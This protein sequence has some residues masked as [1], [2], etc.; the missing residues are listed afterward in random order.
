MTNKILFPEPSTAIIHSEKHI[1]QIWL[2]KINEKGK[3]IYLR[4]LYSWILPTAVT[5]EGWFAEETD[6]IN[7]QNNSGK[8]IKFEL[9]KGEFV[10]NGIVICQYLAGLL[11]GKNLSE[12][13][14]D[15]HIIPNSLINLS[16]GENESAIA[17]KF[18]VR[19]EVLLPIDHLLIPWTHKA[20]PSPADFSVFV[21]QLFFLPKVNLLEFKEYDI[22]GVKTKDLIIQLSN[23]I[24]NATGFNITKESAPR[25]GNLEWF[26]LPASDLN[27]DPLISFGVNKTDELTT[28]SV[29][30]YFKPLTSK[31][32]DIVLRCRIINSEEVALDE[33]RETR[34]TEETIEFEFVCSQ[35]ASE[36]QVTVWEYNQ[37]KSSAFIIFEQSHHCI[38]T[39]STTT[40]MIGSQINSGQISLLDK[41]NRKEETIKRA[42]LAKFSRSTSAGTTEIG[43]YEKDPWVNSSRNIIGF[44]KHLFPEKSE[45]KFFVNGWDEQQGES[46]Q[47]LFVEWILKI[48]SGETESSLILLDPFLD[49]DGIEI[50]AHAR[51]TNTQY[52]IV[53]CTQHRERVDQTTET[54]ATTI[55]DLTAQIPKEDTVTKAGITIQN[56]CKVILPLL[57]SLNLTI[58]DLR[59]EDKGK[60]QL[61]HD[62]YLLLL[63]KDGDLLKGFH[64]SNSLQGATRKAPLLVT[65]IP[66]DILGEVYK[67][68]DNLINPVESS[69]GSKKVELVKLYPFV[70]EARQINKVLVGTTHL[71]VGKL[72]EIPDQ[73]LFFSLLLNKKEIINADLNSLYIQLKEREIL[74]DDSESFLIFNVTPDDLAIF[75]QGL[76]TQNECDFSK[77][78]TALGECLARS[79]TYIHVSD[80]D[81]KAVYDAFQELA[82]QVKKYPGLADKLVT[83]INTYKDGAS[84]RD[85]DRIFQ[86]FNV[87]SFEDGVESAQ[88]HLSSTSGDFLGI[89]YSYYYASKLLIKCFPH[90]AVKL[91]EALIAKAVALGWNEAREEVRSVLTLISTLGQQFLRYFTYSDEVTQS[92]WLRSKDYRIR[93]ASVGALIHGVLYDHDW[94]GSYTNFEHLLLDCLVDEEYRL[95]I[96]AFNS[97][98]HIRKNLPNAKALLE[99]SYKTISNDWAGDEQLITHVIKVLGGRLEHNYSY[100][101]SLNF[102]DAIIEDNKLSV[103]WCLNFWNTVFNRKIQF[104]Q[105]YIN[106]GSD[107]LPNHFSSNTDVELTKTII[108]YFRKLSTEEQESVA[109]NWFNGIAP[110]WAVI[111]QPFAYHSNFNSFDG[112]CERILWVKIL[113]DKLTSGGLTAK[114]QKQVDTFLALHGREILVAEKHANTRRLAPILDLTKI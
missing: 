69:L 114:I 5:K 18:T 37:E 101:I 13:E 6:S 42:N 62:R 8:T 113:I 51:T 92:I 97:E 25:L 98:I 14:I 74:N 41:L 93:A 23:H 96:G 60:Q 33:V 15:S 94:S 68:I 38:R 86:L 103:K 81:P 55:I 108:H 112:A 24:R 52:H 67:Y 72:D 56:A 57:K 88:S 44:M 87:E 111:N 22:S 58:T 84:P 100:S 17:E 12:I 107:S 110:M 105:Q 45:G 32:K 80:N 2:L 48:I 79:Q 76:H 49:K 40:A 91:L 90:D 89:K 47:L 26:R 28:K 64:L 109:A 53:T 65:P 83:F 20:T 73:N 85:R 77:T 35:P 78:I 104:H 71:S 46:G 3:P 36:I 43:G 11:K 39:I 9:I 59:S 21:C 30:V 95:A 31:I 82:H 75:A 50:F 63:N 54:N 66:G 7:L 102:L 4:L 106:S 61:F 10:G 34:W 27:L 70:D 99:Q 1:W 16:L 29:S 19:P